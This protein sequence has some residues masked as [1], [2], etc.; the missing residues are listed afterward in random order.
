VALFQPS[1]T[2]KKT[3]KKKTSAVWW[4]KFTYAGKPVRESAKTTRKTVAAE[5]EKR[6]RLELEKTNAGMPTEKRENRIRSVAD[7]VKP[8]LKRYEQDHRGREKSILF[9]GFLFPARAISNILTRICWPAANR[10]NSGRSP[11]S[12]CSSALPW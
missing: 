5:A 6:R 4:Y 1:Y 3:G 11:V 10:I 2:D 12:R 7:V 8:Y 9:V